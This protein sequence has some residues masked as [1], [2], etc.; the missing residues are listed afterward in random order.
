MQLVGSATDILRVISYLV[1]VVAAVS[2]MVAL[3][4]TMNERRREIA[5]MR[6]LGARRAQILF[7]ILQ[8]ALLVSLLGAVLGVVF[9]HAAAYLFSG[10]V[11]ERTG[12]TIGWAVFSTAEIWLILGVGVLGAAAGILPAVKGSM[13][14][15][16]DNLGQTS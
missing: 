6:S 8:E 4:N 14:Q 7:V 16:A 9:C 12:V 1:L 2:I 15:V 11:A 13:T 3:Y 10:S 5:I